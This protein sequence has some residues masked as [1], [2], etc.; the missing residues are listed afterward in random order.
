[1]YD[2]LKAIARSA[3]EHRVGGVGDRADLVEFQLSLPSVLPNVD[4]GSDP[5]C[6]DILHGDNLV[7]R[8][9]DA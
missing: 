9:H 5:P 7:F 2:R 6:S 3:G 1:M 8:V 4:T